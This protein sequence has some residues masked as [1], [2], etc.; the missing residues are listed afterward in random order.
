M[1]ESMATPRVQAMD[2]VAATSPKTPESTS[3]LKNQRRVSTNQV[4]TPAGEPS[5]AP[6]DRSATASSTTIKGA[7]FKTPTKSSPKV[8]QTT[9]EGS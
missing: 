1:P 7:N 6:W 3:R 9:M 2:A 4:R 5:S 8:L